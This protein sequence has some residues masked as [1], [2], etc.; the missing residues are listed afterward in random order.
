MLG[1]RECS[2]QISILANSMAHSPARKGIPGYSHGWLPSF[3]SV[4]PFVGN[5]SWEGMA[6]PCLAQR[7]L[8][9]ANPTKQREKVLKGASPPGEQF[10]TSLL[11][12]PGMGWVGRS[13]SHSTPP[14]AE[15]PSLSTVLQALSNVSWNI[16]RDGARRVLPGEG[17]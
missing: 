2:P 6:Q 9:P 17:E 16:P 15:T 1:E 10:Q 5:K 8:P 11:I 13:S 3:Q 7:I 4:E 12:N 14:W